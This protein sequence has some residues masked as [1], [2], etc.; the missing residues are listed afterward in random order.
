MKL[1]TMNKLF[2]ISSLLTV[3]PTTSKAE[4][5]YMC[6]PCPAGYSCNN[7]VK[8]ICPA[9]SYSVAMSTSCTSCPAGTYSK[10]GASSC[11]PCPDGQWQNAKGQSSCKKCT[12]ELFLGYVRW[13]DSYKYKWLNI[14][15]KI[16]CHKF[17]FDGS[18]DSGNQWC[19]A[20]PSQNHAD[21]NLCAAPAGYYD[22]A[23]IKQKCSSDPAQ[24]KKLTMGCDKVTG[25][26]YVEGCLG[27]VWAHQTEHR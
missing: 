17:E 26:L 24:Y 1:K 14:D 13:S 2:L 3:S 5:V 9:G 10:A 16:S 27:R 23:D 22:Y 11:T 25:E 21:R 20:V 19:C 12:G 6:E 15:S 7:G 18:V 4:S 8:T